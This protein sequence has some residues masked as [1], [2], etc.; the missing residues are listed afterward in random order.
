MVYEL[1]EVEVSSN[2]PQVFL[3]DKCIARKRYIDTTS[4]RLANAKLVFNQDWQLGEARN[5][6]RRD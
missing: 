1:W 4:K 2:L 6:E 5:D 3:C